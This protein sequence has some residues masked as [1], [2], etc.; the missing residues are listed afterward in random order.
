MGAIT[1]LA[2]INV[3]VIKGIAPKIPLE[4]IFKRILPFLAAVIIV[5]M[6]LIIFLGIATFLTSL[7]LLAK[8]PGLAERC[9][10]KDADVILLNLKLSI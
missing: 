1:P 10:S 6:I 7:Q 9:S 8:R 2:E 3:F 4:T 5:T